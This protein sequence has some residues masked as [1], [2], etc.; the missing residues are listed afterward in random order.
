TTISD[1]VQISPEDFQKPSAESIE[2]NL[3]AKY[4]NKVVQKIGL[5]ICVYDILS[6][7]DGLIGHGTGIV[8]VNVECRLIVFRPFKGEIVA[9]RISSAS[10][11][12]MRIALDF[13]DDIFVP[14]NLLFPDSS[15]NSQE[16]C[17]VWS[18]E[19]QEYFYD[20]TDWVRFRVEQEHWTDLSPV[21]P[22]LRE[23]AAYMERKSPYSITASMMQAGLGPVS[24]M[25]QFPVFDDGDVE[26]QLTRRPK[27]RLLLHSVVL[28]LNSAWFKASF[29]ERWASEESNNPGPT[30][31]WKYELDFEDQKVASLVKENVPDLSLDMTDDIYFNRNDSYPTGFD[32]DRRKDRE[33]VVKAYRYYVGAMYHEPIDIQFTR[34]TIGFKIEVIT[35]V[36]EIV[37]IGDFYDGLRC[38]TSPVECYLKDFYET[39]SFNNHVMLSVLPQIRLKL[40][41]R[42]LF[43]QVVCGLA[44]EAYCPE[45]HIGNHL[46]PEMA[47]LVLEKRASF[48]QMMLD[49]D[50]E[51]LSLDEPDHAV[52]DDTDAGHIAS[53]YFRQFIFVSLYKC[54]TREWR[55]YLS[56]YRALV[57]HIPSIDY[58]FELRH[59]YFPD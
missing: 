10:E 25:N 12:G 49:L 35:L 57:T 36:S 38:L 2:D 42:W 29:N 40:E 21:A 53:S 5:C 48:K 59:Y 22:S 3:N 24:I 46:N 50:D 43:K 16:Q 51:L 6:A 34:G 30:M 41:S 14:S 18:N 55:Q 7:S 19:G 23:T 4:A 44:V 28:S 17:W 33:E 27:D 8:N 31:R 13:F 54:H 11:D 1:L 26:I 9:G 39:E 56:K 32:E 15:F 20:K 45:D 47:S 37:K 52:R 58:D